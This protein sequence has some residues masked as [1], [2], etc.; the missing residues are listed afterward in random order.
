LALVV[1]SLAG[2]NSTLTGGVVCWP[3]QLGSAF[4]A[5]TVRVFTAVHS[6]NMS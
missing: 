4:T 5:V 2:M 6:T 1:F 3:V